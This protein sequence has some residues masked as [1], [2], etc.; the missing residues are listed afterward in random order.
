MGSEFKIINRYFHHPIHRQDVL[1][2]PGDDCALLKVPPGQTLAVTIDT[3]I[4]GIHFFADVDPKDLGYK[5]LAVNLSDLAAMGATPA[6]VTLAITLPDHDPT[7]LA[8]FHQGFCSLLDEFN[9]ALVGGDLT[10]GPVLTITCQA[11]GF[12]PEGSA[13][14]RSAARAGDLI[15]VTGDLGDAGLALEQLNHSALPPNA[16]VLAKLLCPTPRVNAGLILR[17]YA[18][19]AIDISDGLI[20]DLGHILEESHVGA[21]LHVD[22]LPLSPTLKTIPIQDAYRLALSAGDDYE[23][24]FTVSPQQ[25]T[26]LLA[27]LGPLKTKVTCI[28]VIE[29]TLGLRLLTADQRVYEFSSTGYEHF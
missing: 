10:R 6:W 3:L 17:Q 15:Y 21:T 16:A 13:L 26:P 25:Q 29:P 5:A 19:A 28:G 20:A 12:L 7:W 24:C 18:H 22:D 1:L 2:G 9:V 11:H 27:A 4:A 8:G 14:R 23:L